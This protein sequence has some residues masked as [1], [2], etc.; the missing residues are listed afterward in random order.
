MY[1]Y[2][3]SVE[4]SGSY[5]KGFADDCPQFSVADESDV[6]LCSCMMV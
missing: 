1:M 4:D 5:F 6:V 2:S 3:H